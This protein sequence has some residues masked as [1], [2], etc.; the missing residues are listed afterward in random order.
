MVLVDHW[1]GRR[2]VVPQNL[3]LIF[4]VFPRKM[5]TSMLI[6]AGIRKRIIVLGVVIV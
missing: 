5:M 1:D 6:S 3:L 2:E 4:C